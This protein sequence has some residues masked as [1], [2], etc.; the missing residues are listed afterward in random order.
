MEDKMGIAYSNLR[1][2]TSD[3]KILVG[4]IETVRPQ[5]KSKLR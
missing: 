4:N 1:G 5:G 3:C 2:I